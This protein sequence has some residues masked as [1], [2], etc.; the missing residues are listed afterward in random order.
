M[1]FS[2]IIEPSVNTLDHYKQRYRYS[3][4]LLRQLVV[5]EFKLRYQGSALGYVWTLLRPLFMFIILYLVFGVVFNAGAN[6]PH[7]PVYL[8]LGILLWNYFAEVTNNGVGAIVSKGD[9]LRKLNF[10]KYVIVLAGSISAMINLLI[11]FTVLIIFMVIA[12]VDVHWH[13]LLFI[14]I[15]I[16]LFVFSL[17]V[18]FLL[19]ALF[20]RFRDVNYIWEIIMQAAFYLTPILYPITLV[21][22]RSHLAAQLLLL[23]PMA[24]IIQDARYVLI[25]PETITFE[26]LFSIGW[27][28]VIPIIITILLVIVSAFYF[29]R[30]SPKFA[31]DI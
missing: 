24:Q 23:N 7:Y 13:A 14:P 27:Y 6:I 4:I 21:I 5:T 20:V 9:L 3:A 16:E 2:G 11:N 1:A 18:A 15:V 22:D 30:Q 26:G 17:G 19:S 28:R 8:L 12:G 25:T 10:P 29:R 31:E